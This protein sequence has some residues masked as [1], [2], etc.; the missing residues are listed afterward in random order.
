LTASIVFSPASRIIIP[1]STPSSDTV[2][3]GAS[4]LNSAGNHHVGREDDGRAGIGRRQHDPPRR[5]ARSGSFKDFPTSTPLADRNVFR[6]AAADH[7][8]VHFVDEIGE[9][10]DLGGHLGPAHDGKHRFAR[11]G[12]RLLERFKFLLHGASGIGRKETRQTF[13]GGMCA[14]RGGEGVVNVNVADPGERGREVRIVRLLTGVETGVLQ[15][16]YGAIAEPAYMRFTSLRRMQS[17]RNPTGRST[18]SATAG[19]I[20]ASDISGTRLPFGRSKCA[21]SAT[22]APRSDSSRIVG[23]DPLDAGRVRHPAI[24]D[25][26]IQIDPKQHALA[27]EVAGIVKRAECGAM[28]LLRSS[29]PSRPRCR[30]SGSKSPTRCRTS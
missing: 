30:S 10:F 17:S 1:G 3:C 21:S 20:G 14:M 7:Q 19:A 23:R 4:A 24:S 13:G 8:R 28:P 12:K 15:E 22:R 2:R 25:R 6:H 27:P 29:S 5:P 18:T 16:D 26:H 11:I 9:E